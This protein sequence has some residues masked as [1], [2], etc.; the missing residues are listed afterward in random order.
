MRQIGSARYMARPPRFGGAGRRRASSSALAIILAVLAMSPLVAE[1]RELHGPRSE[2]IAALGD[3]LDALAVMGQHLDS[4]AVCLQPGGGGG[5]RPS[6]IAVTGRSLVIECASS[7]GGIRAH[8]YSEFPHIV[9]GVY[10]DPMVVV[11]PGA[12][13]ITRCNPYREREHIFHL[14]AAARCAR[15]IR[16]RA[17]ASS[18]DAS[19]SAAKDSI[20]RTILRV[21]Y[22]TYGTRMVR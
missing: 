10:S 12:Q 18:A 16:R 15:C 9:F 8:V 3:P 7:A 17:C 13:P 11:C 4:P 14:R 19:R 6:A 5:D 1:A 20:D 2:D 21:R 22:S